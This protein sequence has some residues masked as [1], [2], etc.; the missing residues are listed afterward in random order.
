MGNNNLQ[1]WF[2]AA[3]DVEP[4][5]K[6]EEVGAMINT[7]PRSVCVKPTFKQ[8]I[9]MGALLIIITSL[10]YWMN[11]SSEKPAKREEKQPRIQ[12]QLTVIHSN[13]AKERYKQIP[14]KQMHSL[15]TV[16]GNEFVSVEVPSFETPSPL[17]TEQSLEQTLDIQNRIIYLTEQDFAKIDIRFVKNGYNYCYKTYKT[18]QKIK[19]TQL[20]SIN[21]SF[22]FAAGYP[23][24][25]YFIKPWETDYYPIYLTDS[26]GN[27]QQNF[28][29]QDCPSNMDSLDFVD[30]LRKEFLGSYADLVPIAISS[31]KNGKLNL[32]WYRPTDDFYRRLP[33]RARELIDI[34][35][36]L[37]GSK[38]D[39]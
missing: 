2:A 20:R 16:S 10:A 11:S 27:N 23:G 32:L 37:N 39:R 8:F 14:P 28:H 29:F 33:R 12:Q 24:K 18:G 22:Y 38:L 15:I 31:P 35:L 9:S 25:N 30:S 17:T 36:L 6:V 34:D 3:A 1:K 19:A 7:K 13:Q 26:L 21:D 4:I 5:V